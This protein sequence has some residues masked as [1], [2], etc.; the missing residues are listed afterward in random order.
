MSETWRNRVATDDLRK[1]RAAIDAIPGMARSSFYMPLE[2]GGHRWV[3]SSAVCDFFIR[4]SLP[5]DAE[6]PYLSATARLRIALPGERQLRETDVFLGPY[7]TG[8]FK[9]MVSRIAQAM[10][11]LV[12]VEHA[13]DDAAAGR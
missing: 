9:E 1:L 3:L 11:S 4:A 2:D 5:R 7:G 10:A 13:D 8:S 12:K 6:R